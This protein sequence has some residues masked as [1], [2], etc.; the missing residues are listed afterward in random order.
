MANVKSLRKCENKNLIANVKSPF[1]STVG[2]TES[3]RLS[4]G[5]DVASNHGESRVESQN[6]C[7]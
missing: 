5:G 7:L 4:T 3:P 1:M 2:L 6:L